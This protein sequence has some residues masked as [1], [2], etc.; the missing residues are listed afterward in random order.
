MRACFQCLLI[1]EVSGR[2]RVRLE[3]RLSGA[4]GP[5]Q[6][7]KKSS[8]NLGW[9]GV[10]SI[11]RVALRGAP[12]IGFSHKL[13]CE[14]HSESCSENAPE[15]QELLRECPFHSESVFFKIGVV[16][17][18]LRLGNRCALISSYSRAQS[19]EPTVPG[20]SLRASP[21]TVWRPIGEHRW[22]SFLSHSWNQSGRANSSK[23]AK[24][25]QPRRKFF[26]NHLW[27]SQHIPLHSLKL[28]LHWRL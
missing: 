20:D 14:S 9:N 18:S 4:R 11:L 15:F 16:P 1:E 5:P 22:A 25:Q 26:R 17:R 6:F 28:V 24:Q 7:W 13:G 27:Q 3:E 8:E 2:L 19:G 23:V 21:S 12:R 10:Q